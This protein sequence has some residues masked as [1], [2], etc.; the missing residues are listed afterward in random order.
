MRAPPV[1]P[2]GEIEVTI[3]S[4]FRRTMP[5]GPA[6]AASRLR[7]R[8]LAA[9][10]GQP[11]AVREGLAAFGDWRT[12]TALAS[13]GWLAAALRDTAGSRRIL[14]KHLRLLGAKRVSL[15]G[16]TTQ[17]TGAAARVSGWAV[18][19]SARSSHIWIHSEIT[20]DNVRLSFEEGHDFFLAD[21]TAQTVRVIAAGG[22]LIDGAGLV[23]RDQ[24]EVFG[25]VDRV[26]DPGA[27]RDGSRRPRGEPIAL[28]LRSGDALPLIVRKIVAPG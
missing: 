27:P 21:D 10:I 4:G 9:A 14:Y 6:G 17:P 8:L 1:G 25:F 26:V 22:F 18:R 15:Q 2:G 19:S 11:R 20:T 12:V 23:H 13:S 7:A 3:P 28:A 16:L 24:V 5:V